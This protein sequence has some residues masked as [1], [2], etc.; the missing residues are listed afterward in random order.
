MPGRVRV[1]T[2]NVGGLRLEVGGRHVAR[3]AVRPQVGL[4]SDGRPSAKD[5]DAGILVS[6]DVVPTQG[7]SVIHD[8]LRARGIVSVA[9]V[10]VL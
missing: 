8:S 2:D 1:E 9:D 3:Q 5:P 4:L 7:D 6:V 10:H